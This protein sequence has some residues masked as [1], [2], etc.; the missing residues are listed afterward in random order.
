MVIV[1]RRSRVLIGMSVLDCPVMKKLNA[2]VVAALLGCT[3]ASVCAKPDAARAA[4]QAQREMRVQ[5]RE[6]QRNNPVVVRDARPA[7]APPSAPTPSVFPMATPPQR[8]PAAMQPPPQQPQFAQGN[9]GPRR[10]TPEERQQL[11][12]QIRDARRMYQQGP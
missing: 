1:K 7:F 11:R 8:P 5:Q 3:A 10:L 6:A 12:D 4:Q 9:G 2:F